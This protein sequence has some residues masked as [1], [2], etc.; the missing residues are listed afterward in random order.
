VIWAVFAVGGEADQRVAAQLLGQVDSPSASRGLAML[1][2]SSRSAEVRRVAASTLIRRDPR[3]FVS[4]LIARLRDPIR[5]QVRPV[6]GPGRPGA[7]LI[8]GDTF[9]RGRL[10]SPPPLPDVPVTP[11]SSL[12][13]DASGAAVLWLTT[14]LFGPANVFADPWTWW[15]LL[16]ATN[17]PAPLRPRLIAEELGPNSG[18]R[19]LPYANRSLIGDIPARLTDEGLEQVQVPIG[20]MVA[21]I[22]K[23]AYVAQQQLLADVKVLEKQNASILRRNEPIV[24][25]LGMVVDRKLDGTRSAWAQWW[26]EEQGFAYR[27]PDAS[28]RPT[29]VEEVPLAYQ[30]APVDRY[31][32]QPGVGYTPP[33]RSTSCFAAGTPVLTLDGPRPIESI[34]VGDRVLT[35]DTAGGALSYQPVVAIYHNPPSATSRVDLGGE[36]IV[37]TNIHRFWKAGRGWVMARDLKPGDPVRILGGTALVVAVEPQPI[38]RV[39]NL[40]VAQNQ[41]FFVG[42][43]GALVHDNS[44][45]EPSPA[46][47]D[48]ARAPSEAE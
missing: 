10:Y 5:Y 4:I 31:V 43:L 39:Y 28:T 15:L 18:L 29:V 38:Q 37:A 16:R 2:V 22:R 34:R 26:T 36:A 17:E 27:A 48:A 32:Y 19:I 6:G 23:T 14:G 8:E 40:E 21:E 44:L 25:I 47:F 7:L 45:V 35:Q 12:E 13:R 3:E 24:H 9:N 42:H 46:P 20:K 41:S 11:G 30:P 1:A 33:P